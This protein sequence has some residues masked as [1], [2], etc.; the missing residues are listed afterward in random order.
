MS[1]PET[2]QEMNKKL[3][4][5]NR[6]LEQTPGI[7]QIG[8]EVPRITRRAKDVAP[9]LSF[10]QEGMWFIDQL[11]MDRNAYVM[12]VAYRIEGM[13][14]S[15][16]LERCLNEIIRRH[17][18]LRTT[19]ALRD[20]APVQ[21]IAPELMI[22]LT[23]VHMQML[24]DGEREQQA[25]AQ[26]LALASQP[27]NLHT[28]PL[29]RATLF[30]LE[31]D[32]HIF[33]FV[34][35][36]ILFDGWSTGLLLKEI[37]AL[38]EA[39]SQKQPSPLAELPIQYA[40]Y[41]I[42]QRQWMQNSS[43]QV[44]LDYWQQ[45]L[46]SAPHH[47][48]LATDHARPLTPTF[49]GDAHTLRISRELTNA[50][51]NLSLQ[52]EA[53]PFMTCL[54]AFI[55]LLAR[56]TGQNDIVVGSAIAGRQQ[57]EVEHLMGLFV[58]TLVLRTRLDSE[59]TFLDV[60]AEVRETALEAYT[61]QD[62]PFAKLVQ[63]LQPERQSG[64]NPLFQVLFA[65][66]QLST[67]QAT[68][69]QM[70]WQD[71]AIGQ[72]TTKFDL[73]LYVHQIDQHFEITL[74]YNTDLFES[75]TTL[76]MLQHYQTLLEQIVVAPQQRQATIS[77]LSDSERKQILGEWYQTAAIYPDQSTLQSLFE[78]Q[79]DQAPEHVAVVFQ[80]QHLT[81]QVLNQRANRLAHDLLRQGAGPGTQLGICVERSLDM[82]IGILAI[83]K[84]GGAYVPLD[85][86]YPEE[87]LAFMVRDA[88]VH[89]ILTRHNLLPYLPAQACTFIC[90][91][92]N[93]GSEQEHN[94]ADLAC[95][96]DLAYIMYTSGSTGQPKGV[97]AVQRGVIRLVKNT[98]YMCFDRSETFLAFAPISFD[99]STLEIWGPLLNGGRLVILPPAIPASEELTNTLT[100]Y[101]VTTLWL[102][103]GLF[104]QVVE[105]NLDDL[106]TVRQLLAGGDV[107]S[108]AHVQKVLRS[109]K[110]ERLINGYGPTENTTFTCC[111]SMQKPLPDGQ[112]SV[113]IG[114]PIANTQVYLLDDDMQ[115]VPV[116]IPGELY[117]GGDGL[118]RSYYKR[119]G[120][121][122]EHFLPD[123]ISGQAG[124]R[125]YRSG[126]L[127]RYLPDG[128]LQFLGR[129]D[130]Q[131]KVRGFR[132][133]LAEIDAAIGQLPGILQVS[134]QVYTESE[135]DNKILIAYLVVDPAQPF[136]SEQMRSALQERLP[137]YM[138]PAL[139]IKLPELPLTPNGKI[140]REALPGPEFARSNM[141]E[142]FVAPASTGEKL[143]ADIWSKVLGI[144]EIGIYDNFF[145]LGGDSIRSIRIRSQLKQAGID[146]S[147]QQI[148][149]HQTI[150]ALAQVLPAE[151][152]KQ[153]A[154]LPTSAFSL[155]SEN[156]RA[157]LPAEVEDAYPLTRLQ[158]GMIYHAELAGDGS[159]YHNV[160]SLTLHSKQ[161]DL[162]LLEQAI[163]QAIHQHPVLR[164]AFDMSTYSQ[165]LQLVYRIAK[166]VIFREDIQ[167]KTDAEKQIS[168]DNLIRYERSHTFDLN[169]PCL[170]RCFVHLRSATTLQLTVTF[171]HTILDGWSLYGILADI[172]TA[173]TTGLA[174]G[175]LPPLDTFKTSFRD[176][177]YLEQQALQSSENRAYWQKQLQDA[178]ILTLPRWPQRTKA[179]DRRIKTL[180][181]I[182]PQEGLKSLARLA[183]VP[184]KSV[185]LAAHS[186]VLQM[187]SG[188][189][190]ILTGVTTDGRPEEL[191]GDRIRGLF[192]NVLPF[193][194]Q[195]CAES[196]YDL[197]QKCFQIEREA[198]P[199]RRYPLSEMQNAIGGQELLQTLFTFEHFHTIQQA[200]E[201]G[202]ISILDSIS[203]G[204]A[205]FALSVDFGLDP[206][207]HQLTLRLD[208]ARAVF[209]DEQME[210]ICAYYQQI[211][212][213]MATRP[214]EHHE[215]RSFL[216]S[217]EYQRQ[218]ETWN[219]RLTETTGTKGFSQLFNEQVARTPDALAII[220][221][222]RHVTYHELQQ[223]VER[224]AAH[225]Q[226]LGVG[227]EQIVALLLERGIE[228]ISAF[229]ALWQIGAACLP[230]DPTHP[231]NR[232]Q[233]MF[234][235]SRSRLVLT[236]HQHVERIQRVVAAWPEEERPAI[237]QLE[238][239]PP[240]RGLPL[241]PVAYQP[242]RLA[243][244]MFT[245]GSTGIPKG[246]CVE[247]EG[248]LNHMQAKVADV[249]LR[250]GQRLAQNSPVGFDIVIW[251]CLAPF[252]VG[253]TVTVAGDELAFDPGNLLRWLQ[254]QR[255]SVL[256]VVPSM[257]RALLQEVE[258]T[259]I[260]LPDLHWIVPTGD[261]LPTDVCTRW[262][263]LFPQIPVLNTYGSTEC[264][265]DQCH[266]AIRH[267]PGSDYELPI[268][269]IGHPIP[270][271]R[272]YILDQWYMPVPVGVA[273]DLY[274]GGT[275]V[276]RGYLHDPA[277][278]AE[279]FL[280]D[281]FARAAGARMYRTRD[282]A[283]FLPGGEI[284]FLG[285]VDQVIKIRG[286]RIEP[287]EIEKTLL[288]HPA[289][290]DCVVVV[291]QEE[292]RDKILVA[293]IVP[294]QPGGE[295]KTGIGE[296]LR[297]FLGE[298]L[299]AHMVPGVF[300]LLET[301]PLNSNGKVDRKQLPPPTGQQARDGE[302]FVTP[303]TALEQIINDIFAEILHRERI[304]IHE[305][306]FECGG[307]SLLAT[308]V[309]SRIRSMLQIDLPLKMLFTYP[310]TARLAAAILEHKAEQ[311]QQIEKIALLLVELAALSDE[312]VDQLFAEKIVTTEENN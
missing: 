198:L 192:L 236:M 270:G 260:V 122:A 44:H 32:V 285:R 283:R 246:A 278:T 244:I 26:I 284:E 97:S 140:D 7:Q 169:Q 217:S 85:A 79:V 4:L 69:A 223:E 263:N 242:Q 129:N 194:I 311:R 209:C 258:H 240:Q 102:T 187:I 103:A 133:E 28:G 159:V 309:I 186:K 86:T 170:L 9:P 160:L 71:Y 43:Q 196:W 261:A 65:F 139:F 173:Y 76:Y 132:I 70:R 190:D 201:T 302:V 250:A 42:W 82:L 101:G 16:L 199:F 41:A 178:S 111:Y 77:L 294:Q 20:G 50:L 94:P 106:T 14:D 55:I 197:V 35:H 154:A 300:V 96:D 87:R 265:D 90:L 220:T 22:K 287:G 207:S 66:E 64:R 36:H 200:N 248:M 5:L 47:L 8:E 151:G 125:L 211:L 83:I 290:Q 234:S 191:D 306:F 312:E 84:T 224:L 74:A 280:P 193:R 147:L 296:M 264:S 48:E 15:S 225:L 273:G 308:Q 38:Y 27:M 215:T 174:K 127:A 291:H 153:G 143:L 255:I 18:S 212:H 29:V 267:A 108:I 237:V 235:Q 249:E 24:D 121:T 10:A 243:Y 276:G 241:E 63:L 206:A 30:H 51:Q 210:A 114:R 146:L 98:N 175:Q 252:L 118:A 80:D 59:Q 268:I 162:D 230:L 1:E 107:L 219:R 152:I 303:R 138:V 166:P 168:I 181:Y 78:N 176:F 304:S 282:L 279:V 180:R 231:D 163:L 130:R 269:P 137:A 136:T 307:H 2:L 292:Q 91:D 131:V 256:Q 88:D 92:D 298:K 179:G 141:L 148:F 239:L 227:P 109:G 202:A 11:Q 286:H 73:S 54:A 195:L 221:Q 128:T 214:E 67:D 165:P 216:T 164:T 145:A 39:F 19:F 23:D 204:D 57:L 271:M 297:Q 93:P 12:P 171:S 58:N 56:Y 177:V 33:L 150:H 31:K 120:L 274:I 21:Q 272:A 99:A 226:H 222:E 281:P 75:A 126:D 245:S 289:V 95:A 105:Q 104:H 213:A 116:G 253:A 17:E 25:H 45:K 46:E 205:S 228:L 238:K 301:L 123:P 310:T 144:S 229:L 277:K 257:M 149:Q 172:F 112:T 259:S 13:L 251:Q 81:Y 49:H 110:V 60:L 89:L 117:I 247:Q 3:A 305:H 100:R 156:D 182:V 52:A 161:I 157:H 203:Y 275:G 295:E 34:I 158:A 184:L 61:H 299:P 155:I 232:Y 119:P 189:S 124:A 262:L 208:F 288:Q 233:Q 254:K 142:H 62:V 183:S 218:I 37:A 167:H 72:E 185:L 188:Q 6:L 293:Y 113:P 68:F 134:T 40:D 135:S 53:T 266:V 115:P